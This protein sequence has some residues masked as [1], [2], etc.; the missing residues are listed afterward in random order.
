MY[1]LRRTEQ[2]V[3]ITVS[4]SVSDFHF[5]NEKNWILKIA[6]FVCVLIGAFSLMSTDTF[7]SEDE[8][9]DSN[10]LAWIQCMFIDF[11]VKGK[12]IE[13][14]RVRTLEGSDSKW[15]NSQLRQTFSIFRNSIFLRKNEKYCKI[16]IE[17]NRKQKGLNPEGSEPGYAG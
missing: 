8:A 11:S 4:L 12:E 7:S 3:I 13:L 16:S 6:R 10:V 17:I 1:L 2:M 5:E 14:S 9:I 15:A